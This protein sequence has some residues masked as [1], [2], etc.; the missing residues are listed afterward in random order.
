MARF[1]LQCQLHSTLL[2]IPNKSSPKTTNCVCNF[3]Q[4]MSKKEMS[5]L[6]R[7]MLPDHLEPLGGLRIMASCLAFLCR[8]SRDGEIPEGESVN[9]V[10]RH[11]YHYR[12]GTNVKCCAPRWRLPCGH[13][14][15]WGRRAIH[16]PSTPSL[17]TPRS[18]PFLFP[19]EKRTAA[20]VCCSQ[21]ATLA[22]GSRP[23]G[24]PW[25]ANRW[26]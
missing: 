24:G 17:S 16:R 6:V 11:V 7:Q 9:H 13:L 14:E 21:A 4:E 20:G 8:P 5:L 25:D 22:V 10:Q 12:T 19:S 18:C 26:P 3:L 23:S 15:G 2:H 1:F